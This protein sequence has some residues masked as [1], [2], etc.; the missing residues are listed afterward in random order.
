MKKLRYLPLIIAAVMFISLTA[1]KSDNQNSGSSEIVITSPATADEPQ[2]TEAPTEL[3]TEPTEPNTELLQSMEANMSLEEKVGQMFLAAKPDEDAAQLARQYNLG[4]YVL[5]AKDIDGKTA[6]EIKAD[7]KAIQTESKFPMLI[8]TDE[9]GGTVVRVSSNPNLRSQPFLSPKEYYAKGKTSEYDN[10]GIENVI[11][12]EK[13]KADL[14][15]SLG[16]NVNLAPVCDITK[17]PESFM[18]DRSFSDKVKNVCDFVAGTVSVYKEKKL[19]SVLKHFP[20][21]GDNVDTHT[22]SAVDNRKYSEFASLDFLPFE[23]GIGHGADAIMV[24]H[25]IITDI[26]SKYP[27]SLSDKVHQVIRRD[28]DF[29]GVI[30]TDD[31]T[32]DAVGNFAENQNAAVLAVKGG[33][34]LICCSDFTSGCKAVI[35]AVKNG[36]IPVEQIDQSVIRI[37]KWKQ[38]LGILGY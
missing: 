26:D 17:N 9:E 2:T 12:Y 29:K 19:G 32:M 27:A 31:I 13:E 15:L 21:Y 5:F 16:I 3:L 35:D 6:D 33:N 28:L 25:N 14:L 23:T 20:G 7:I 30:I 4:G 18:Y 22:G 24:S 10:S 34:D 8:C 1:C 38:N 37:L 36:E 11:K